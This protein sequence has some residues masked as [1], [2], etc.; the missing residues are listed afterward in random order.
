[1]RSVRTLKG[2]VVRK[3]TVGVVEAG[4]GLCIQG[5]IDFLIDIM[6]LAVQS[7]VA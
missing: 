7:I 3:A 6:F 4:V 1:M 2:V 5:E